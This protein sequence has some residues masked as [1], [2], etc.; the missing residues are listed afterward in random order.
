MH[1]YS[2]VNLIFDTCTHDNS[3]ST[4]ARRAFWWNNEGAF[5]SVIL[6]CTQPVTKQT[7]S[8]EQIHP[9]CHSEFI[10]ES[11]V[12]NNLAIWEIPKR[13]R[14]DSYD[15]A[16]RRRGQE[17]RKEKFTTRNSAMKMVCSS[18]CVSI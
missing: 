4:L 14:D 16:S 6:R 11:N 8:Q 13:V 18:S 12:Y 9:I 2:F 1:C 15:T 10:S 17:E 5:I 3:F 7:P